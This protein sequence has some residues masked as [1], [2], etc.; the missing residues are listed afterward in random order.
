MHQARHAILDP[1]KK[2]FSGMEFDLVWISFLDPRF[3][4]MK[5]LN[6]DE[7][8]IAKHCLRDAAAVVARSASEQLST[9]EHDSR[10]IASHRL[11]SDD[12]A[13]VWGDLL[14]SDRDDDISL[15]SDDYPT[16]VSGASMSLLLTLK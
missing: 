15:S 11:P 5:L 6:Q 7:I 12:T 14:G 13:S 3:H 8:V 9:P 2:R 4:K 10:S 16:C 1:I